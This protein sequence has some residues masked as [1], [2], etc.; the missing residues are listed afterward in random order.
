MSE[1]CLPK[2]VG[3]SLKADLGICAGLKAFQMSFE[4]SK[5][6][7]QNASFRVGRLRI[8]KQL[9]MDA[10]LFC[11]T[12]M[13]SLTSTMVLRPSQVT[14]DLGP[15]RGDYGRGWLGSQKT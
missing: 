3:V 8:Y 2:H 4:I 10:K 11:T 9:P 7:C 1:K 15:N 12:S 14:Q 6:S 13:Q 5:T